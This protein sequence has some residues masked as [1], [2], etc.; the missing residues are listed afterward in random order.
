M[1]YTGW[2]RRGIKHCHL[3]YTDSKLVINEA[4]NYSLYR[5]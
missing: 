2:K 1:Q 5:D 3:T 4:F